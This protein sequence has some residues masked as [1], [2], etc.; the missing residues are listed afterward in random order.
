MKRAV[1]ERSS[2][3]LTDKLLAS[4]TLNENWAMIYRCQKISLH[5]ANVGRDTK[6]SRIKCPA[7]QALKM[8]PAIRIDDVVSPIFDLTYGR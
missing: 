7:I 1:R 5:R 8:E 2:P 6:D 4:M 3:L